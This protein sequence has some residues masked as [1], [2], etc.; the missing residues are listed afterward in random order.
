MKV[1]GGHGVFGDKTDSG[2]I[3]YEALLHSVLICSSMSYWWS[4]WFRQLMNL[5]GVILNLT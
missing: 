2:G 1:I 4:Q 3:S 5:S